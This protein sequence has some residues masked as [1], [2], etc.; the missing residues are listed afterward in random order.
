MLTFDIYYINNSSRYD[1]KVNIYDNFNETLVQTY[2]YICISTLI[3]LEDILITNYQY[4]SIISLIIFNFVSIIF[5]FNKW[6]YTINNHYKF[7]YN[8]NI[9]TGLNSLNPYYTLNDDIIIYYTV[10]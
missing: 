9:D 1:I 10:K 3:M 5:L 7:L 6:K 2:V 8:Y 4:I